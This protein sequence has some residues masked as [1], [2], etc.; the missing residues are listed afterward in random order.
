M[1][2]DAQDVMRRWALHPEYVAF[3]LPLYRDMERRIEEFRQEQRM[4]PNA[5]DYD[6]RRKT[7]EILVALMTQLSAA[8]R[9]YLDQVAPS[10]E[11][12]S[13][14]VSRK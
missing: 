5:I 8:T 11:G 1:A 2:M 13:N 6:L 12:G 10:L 9:R 7:D 3:L 14:D 4:D